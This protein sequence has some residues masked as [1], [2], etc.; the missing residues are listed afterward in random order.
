MTIT[1]K[2]IVV[3]AFALISLITLS[4]RFAYAHPGRTASDGCHY[5]RTNCDSWGVPWNARHCHGG[6]PATINTIETEPTSTPVPTTPPPTSTPTST[7][8]LTATSTPMPE[9]KGESTLPTD[10]PVQIES[11]T[12]EV[13]PTAWLIGLGALGVGSYWLIR[14]LQSKTKRENPEPPQES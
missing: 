14:K 9:V 10:I 11:E 5:C 12:E 13:D 3:I 8:I 2:K 1:M 4:V 7:P 6:V